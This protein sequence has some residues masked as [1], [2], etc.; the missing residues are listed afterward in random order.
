MNEQQT[1]IA[2]RTFVLWATLPAIW[3]EAWIKTWWEVYRG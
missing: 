2:R 1:A 3:A